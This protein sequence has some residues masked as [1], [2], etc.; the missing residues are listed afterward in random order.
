MSD[1]PVEKPSAAGPVVLNLDRALGRLLGN[2][3]LLGW[4]VHQFRDEG[5]K[6]RQDL[7]DA[8]TRKD[9][10]ATA[11]AAHRLR[12]QALAIEAV[13]LAEALDRIEQAAWKGDLASLDPLRVSSEVELDRVLEALATIPPPSSMR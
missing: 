12:G 1:N 7:G 13:A 8:I 3:E 11:Y 2:K 9:L 10:T 6:G 5:P 4:M